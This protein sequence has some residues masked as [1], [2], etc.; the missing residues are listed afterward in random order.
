[1]HCAIRHPVAIVE[2]ELQHSNSTVGSNAGPWNDCRVKHHDN[3]PPRTKASYSRRRADFVGPPLFGV[4][5]GIGGIDEQRT[6]RRSIRLRI[7]RSLIG[8]FDRGEH[9]PTTIKRVA[10]EAA[11][12]YRK[13]IISLE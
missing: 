1:M 2:G 3:D 5:Q 12:S 10:L 11:R 9:D 7:A 13:A 4:L 8:T 6:A